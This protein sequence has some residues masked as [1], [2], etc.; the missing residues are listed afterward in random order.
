[1]YGYILFVILGIGVFFLVAGI[2]GIRT[3]LDRL[4][5]RYGVYIFIFIF[6]SAV[7]VTL[8]TDAT[9][10]GFSSWKK[11]GVGEEMVKRNHALLYGVKGEDFTILMRTS[12]ESL[13]YDY[14]K[15]DSLVFVLDPKD[16]DIINSLN[17]IISKCN[18]LKL[19]YE[20]K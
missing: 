17:L 15:Y 20:K 14:S 9:R 3:F 6:L 4:L 18:K 10:D 1:M 8:Y 7:L 19:A 12:G 16:K 11:H 2:F 13:S 5:G